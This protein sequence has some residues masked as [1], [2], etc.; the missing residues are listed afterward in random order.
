M[1]RLE[2]MILRLLRGFSGGPVVKNPLSSAGDAALISGQ[3][4]NILHGSELLSHMRP[5]LQSPCA[6]MNYPTCRN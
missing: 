2:F 6:L 4:T 1:P 3:G 5:Q